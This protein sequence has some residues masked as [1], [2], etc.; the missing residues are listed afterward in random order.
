MTTRPQERWPAFD[1]LRGLAIIGVIAIHAA[2]HD[3]EKAATSAQYW[4]LAAQT[5]LGRFAV[6][7]FLIISGFFVSYKE[8]S[9]ADDIRNMMVRRLQRVVPPYLI[10]SSVY[11]L[12]FLPGG[13]HLA[14]PPVVIFLER[15]ITGTNF[16]HLYFIV[17]VIQL[18]LL[19]S[20]GFMRN[21]H[22][23]KATVIA[24]VAA[25]LVFT[26][27]SYLLPSDASA[28]GGS[29]AG[30]Y[31]RAYER[32]LFPRWLPFFMLGRWLGARWDKVNDYAG[33]R[34]RLMLLVMLGSLA[35]CVLD[36]LCLRRFSGNERL[37]PPD[38]MVS[39][40]LFGS[41][42]AIWFLTIQRPAGVVRTALARLG[43]VSFG[44]YLLHEPALTLF[45]RYLT[46]PPVAGFLDNSFLRQGVS[47]LAGLTASLVF[48]GLLHRAFPG[49]LRRY[50]LG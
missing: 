12:L 7:S 41:S 15:L 35:L 49:K 10:W 22:A 28:L 48:V 33:R 17:L 31:F 43:L 5:M 45:T 18:Y 42:F 40:A 24:A 30:Y 37:L 11:F 4:A 9:G 2:S 39:C 47:V 23:G 27:P 3:A 29:T 13:G 25:F 20:C 1:E 8:R 38:W 14:R 34:R 6:P 16:Y 46:G 50:V 26:L 19:T 36:F 44:V 32:S 21:G